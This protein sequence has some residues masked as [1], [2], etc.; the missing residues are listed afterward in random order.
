MYYCYIHNY[1][2]MHI[3]VKDH[4]SNDSKLHAYMHVTKYVHD[5]LIELLH[6]YISYQVATCI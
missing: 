6:V 2:A 1:I 5:C 3:Y 4:V